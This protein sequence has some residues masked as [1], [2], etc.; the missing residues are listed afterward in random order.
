MIARV[1]DHLP[2][3][4]RYLDGASTAPLGHRWACNGRSRFGGEYRHALVREDA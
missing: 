1:L 3:G 2:D 4:W